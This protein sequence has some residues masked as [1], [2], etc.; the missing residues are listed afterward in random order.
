MASI[1]T[2][3]LTI[4]VDEIAVLGKV[5]PIKSSTITIPSNA[6]DTAFVKVTCSTAGWL[7]N[8]AHNATCK[9]NIQ[10]CDSSGN[11]A[12]TICTKELAALGV[13]RTSV[14]TKTINI[15]ALKGKRVYGK[16]TG[17]TVSG[18]AGVT[19]NKKLN[20]SIL[21]PV[22]AG[23]K[24]L[25]SDFTQ[26][27]LQASAGNKITNSNFSAGVKITAD[28]MNDVILGIS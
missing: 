9:S 22:V 15:S 16:V 2:G 11:N 6:R 20:I 10:L 23:D 12:V 1:Y 27:G 8:T 21:F 25:A 19:I 5:Y 17:V 14:F 7:Y 26:N 13:D 28:R 18:S 3:D 4:E 24:I